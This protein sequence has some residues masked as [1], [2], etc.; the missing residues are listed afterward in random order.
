MR[1]AA[2][3]QRDNKYAPRSRF[4]GTV[5][6]LSTILFLSLVSVPAAAIEVDELIRHI[7][8]LWRGDTSRATMTMTVKTVRYQRSMTMVPGKRLFAGGH[9]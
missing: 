4:P 8:R 5:I 1:P 6:S 7:D 9:S 2:R 3:N